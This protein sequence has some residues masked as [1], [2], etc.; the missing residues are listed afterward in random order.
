MNLGATTDI[1]WSTLGKVTP[2]RNQGNCGSCWAF[3]AIGAVESEVMIKRGLST[4]P[5]LSE[6]QLVSCTRVSPYDNYGCNGG[7]MVPAFKFMMTTAGIATEAKYPY[8][9]SNGSC[10]TALRAYRLSG[11]NVVARD[12]CGD[13]LTA[14]QTRPISVAVDATNWSSYRT[15]VFNNCAVNIN[16]AVLLVGSTASTWRIKNSWG[17]YWG[18]SGFMTISKSTDCGICKYGSFPIL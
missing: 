12:R 15:G 7:W 1:D 6:Q 14:L 3:S 10:R 13:L 9:A 11:Y 4:G 8:T 18:Q 17:I 2:V 16:H 5:N